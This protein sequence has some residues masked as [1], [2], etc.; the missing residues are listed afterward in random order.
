MTRRR[1][2]FFIACAVL[3]AL[4]PTRA[5]DEHGVTL[6]TN[7]PVKMR[8]GIT[9]YADIYRPKDDGKYPVLLQRTPIQQGRRP[10]VRASRRRARLRGHHPGRARALHVRGRVVH[11]QARARRR[12]RHGGVGGH[13]AVLG[14]QGRDVRRLVRRRDADARGHRASAS[15]RRASARSSRRATTTRTGR[16]RAARS[17]SG[18]IS[19]GRQ[20]WRRIPSPATRATGAT[21]SK[22]MNAVAARQVP[23]VQPAG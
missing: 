22:G 9:L 23:A 14:W 3:V 17:R 6:Q 20:G 4:G 2:A 16:I 7:V 13:A 11:V 21:R 19:R 8:D 1:T 5:A 12:V 18:S 15:P 10:R